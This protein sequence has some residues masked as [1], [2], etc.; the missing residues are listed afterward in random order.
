MYKQALYMGSPLTS[1][2]LEDGYTYLGVQVGIRYIYLGLKV[3]TLRKN[4]LKP[5]IGSII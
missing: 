1:S 3:D 5:E 2:Q 4:S